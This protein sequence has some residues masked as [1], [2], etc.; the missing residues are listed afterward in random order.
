MGLL[1]WILLG[2]GLW[3]VGVVGKLLWKSGFLAGRDHEG[4]LW[5]DAIE[6]LYVP[7][8]QSLP[9][10]AEGMTPEELKY[11]NQVY[12]AAYQ[13]AL[14]HIKVDIGNIRRE[15]LEKFRTKEESGPG[16]PV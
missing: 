1:T 16:Y 6:K 7:N 9:I 11:A 8:W 3:G 10:R 2:F 15:A 5:L 14:D 13:T 12:V 4:M